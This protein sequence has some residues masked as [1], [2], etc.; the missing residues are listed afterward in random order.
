MVVDQNLTLPDD[1]ELVLFLEKRRISG[2][3]NW[4]YYFVSHATRSLFWIQ[5]CDPIDDLCISE[6]TA[7]K[8]PYDIRAHILHSGLHSSL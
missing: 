2:G 1:R 8:S 4:C 6:I 7:L 3:Y 5:E